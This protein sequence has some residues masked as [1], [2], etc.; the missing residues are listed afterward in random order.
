MPNLR[1]G[2]AK[3]DSNPGS[4]NC[5][6]GILPL[7]YLAPQYLWILGKLLFI[8]ISQFLPFLQLAIPKIA[9][10]VRTHLSLLSR[11]IPSVFFLVFYTRPFA[12]CYIIA[13]T[14][15]AEP[16]SVCVSSCA[17]LPSGDY[18]SCDGC[19]V[20][21]T[22]SYGRIFPDRPCPGGLKWD[23][24]LKRCDWKSRTCPPKPARKSKRYPNM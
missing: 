4:L 20:Y 11:T 2:I 23:D 16:D 8:S 22:C 17:G 9:C 24:N 3:R 10:P 12:K 7:S 18:Q 19:G 21:V 5:E 13:A 6:S 14:T 1:N 15:T